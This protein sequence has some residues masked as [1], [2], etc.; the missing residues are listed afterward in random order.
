MVFS[1]FDVVEVGFVD[2]CGGGE[3]EGDF[4]RDGSGRRSGAVVRF[5]EVFFP[6]SS[7]DESLL[8]YRFFSL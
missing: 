4:R 8:L 5:V 6:C 3:G 1:P 2:R 7:L